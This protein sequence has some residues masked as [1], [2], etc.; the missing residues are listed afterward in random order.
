MEVAIYVVAGLSNGALYALMALGLVLVYRTQNFIPFVNGEFFTSGA[1][2]GFVSVSALSLPYWMAFFVAVVC[3][4]F[5]GLITERVSVRPIAQSH[6]L[7]LVMATAGT[8][9][10]LQGIARARWGDDAYTLPPVFPGGP[11]EI[12]GVPIAPQNLIVIVVTAVVA[13]SLFVFF[14]YARLGKQMRAVSQSLIGAQIIGISPV[15]IYRYTWA[16]SAGIGAAGGILAAPIMLVYP[17]MGGGMLI[18]GFA[19]AVLGGLTS[20]PG[21]ILGGV[22]IGVSEQLVGGYIGTQFIEISAFV[23]IMAVLLIRPQGLLGT[24]TQGRV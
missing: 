18:K 21:A 14:R 12:A 5:I 4:M 2:I 24:N 17:D 1:F 19:A 23:V 13:A 3:G 7:S 16:L 20:I 6:H 11:I 8:S 15:R 9:I 22:L 10:I